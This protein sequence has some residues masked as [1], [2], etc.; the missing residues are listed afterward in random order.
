MQWACIMLPHLA[1]DG[2]LRRRP[3]SAQ[4]LALIGGSA[5]ARQLVDVNA[6]ARA[7]GLYSGQ[8][9]MAARALLADFATVEY[10]P[11]EVERWRQLL[12]AWAYRYSAEVVQLPGAV[13]LEIS[14]SLNLFGPWP[15][16]EAALRADLQQLG[17]RH[18]L[19]LAPGAH[20]ARV[21]AA[22]GDGIV[23]EDDQHCR[24]LL[25]G[26]PIAHA[27][28]PGD[29]ADAL[30]GMG[31]RHL[32]AV[33]ALPRAG[34][35]RRFGGSL[36]A[37]LDQL[38]GTQPAAL[39]RY[40]P[41]D[42]FD[43]R[44]ELNFEVD[45]VAALVFPLRRLTADLASYLAGRDGGVQRFVLQLEHAQ[46][47][48]GDRAPTELTIG[49]L[50][51]ER[52]AAVLFELA[53]SRLERIAVQH[54]IVSL[55]L[56]AREL[57]PFVPDGRDLFDQRPANAMPLEQLRERLRARLG[58]D[59]VY[60][61]QATHDPRPEFAQTRGDAGAPTAPSSLPRPTW[62]LP[63]PIPL[64]TRRVRVL[65]GPE[66][67]ESGWWDGGDLRRDYYVVETAE[68]QR[69]WAFRAAGEAPAESPDRHDG[70]MLH[71]WFA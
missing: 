61:L 18:R 44:I 32:G 33:L 38:L 26:I 60:R 24:R 51:P 13:A 1:L 55:R 57:P 11:L 4:P 41:P 58:D 67:L 71:G 10:D 53:R 21:L 54:P 28:L 3:P 23:A 7:A 6:S 43:F 16:F 42:C 5:Q 47:D 20:A 48:R 70:W 19:A 12:A 17:F 8:S 25:A 39:P 9:L 66:R 50:H 62:L 35:L 59:A 45:N 29:T 52:D 64:R 56:L 27:G 34:L 65:A 68:G 63:R 69:A 31:I 36:V 40:R 46:R 30:A 14:R 37:Q 49:L 22:T 15:R 2:V